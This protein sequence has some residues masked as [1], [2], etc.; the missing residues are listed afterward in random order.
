MPVL[1]FVIKVCNGIQMQVILLSIAAACNL[2]INMFL[3]DSSKK[4]FSILI[5]CKLTY[6]NSKKDNS[7]DLFLAYRYSN[8]LMLPS[9]HDL[10]LSKLQH[11][12]YLI[13]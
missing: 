10:Q 4:C 9:N 7:N 6:K 5:S 11:S 1:M 2:S 3:H 13:F 8:E 12:K